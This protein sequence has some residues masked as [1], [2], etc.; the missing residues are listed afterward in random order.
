LTVY[1]LTCFFLLLP[2]AKRSNGNK[3]KSFYDPAESR[4]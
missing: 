4:Y 2:A 3:N 1:S